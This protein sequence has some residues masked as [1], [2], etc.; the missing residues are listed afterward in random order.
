MR[1]REG[2]FLIFVEGIMRLSYVGIIALT[3]FP[4]VSIAAQEAEDESVHR[5]SDITVTGTRSEKRLKDT[6]VVTEV[7]SAKEIENSAALTVSDILEDYGLMYTGNAMGDYIQMQGMGE[8]RILFLIDGRRLVGRIASR[9]KGETLPL[10]NVE[11][12]EIVRGPQS[13]LYGSDG[14][15]GVI[16]IITKKPGDRLSLSLSVSNRFLPPYDNPDTPTEANTKDFNPI[17][18][19]NLNAVLGFPIGDL[20]NSLFVEG[21]RSAFYYDEAKNASVLPRNL[22]GK[23]GLDTSF[24]LGNKAE[25]KLG[26]SFLAMRS[27]EQVSARGGLNRLDYLRADAYAE[28]ELFPMEWAALTLR[29]YDN[30]YERNKDTYNGI[31]ET[32]TIGENYENEN[33]AALE[34]AGEYYGF[35]NWILTLG[36]EI[37]YNS[38]D[39]YN[40]R[41]NGTFAAVDKEALFVQAERYREDRYSILLGLRAERSSQFGFFAAPK[42]SA[43]YHLP[44][45]F[46]FLGGAGL[47]Y[48]APDF[49]DLFLVKDDNAN[50]PVVQGNSD[51]M[52]EYALAFNL[53]LEY[54]KEKLFFWQ[55]NGY[56]SEMFDEIFNVDIGMPDALGRAVYDTKNIARSFRTGFDSEA[57]VY[58]LRYGYLSAGYSWL[59]AYDRTEEEE[60]YPQPPHTLKAKLGVDHTKTGIAAYLQGRF[61]SAIPDPDTD[62]DPRFVLDFYFSIAIGK[63]FKVNAAVDN[64]TGLIDPLGP[65]TTQSFTLGL[66]YIL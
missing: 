28:V 8:R 6:P 17:L 11:R 43:M 2:V 19:Q 36:L 7:I 39:K 50:H 37:A 45:G 5:L 14:I 13:A 32:W 4:V 10:G 63:H 16:N 18:E 47:G 56:Y 44:A 52:P 64:I 35:D 1:I 12:I 26:G 25:M 53:A 57:R 61:F 60:L 66:R 9:L 22:R 40:L 54:S 48:R 27:D 30:Y 15:G 3:F 65:Y 42:L 51:L 59:Y 20:R 29:A 23:T 31:Q 46:R 62:Y 34:A 33:Y 24:P 49:S 58:F 21:A 55:I 38:M 41:N